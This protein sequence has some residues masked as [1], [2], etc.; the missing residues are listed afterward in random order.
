[1]SL[2]KLLPYKVLIP[3][4]VLVG[5]APFV[6]RPHLIEKLEMLFEGSLKQPI[7]IFDLFWHSWPIVLLVVKVLTDRTRQS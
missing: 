1:M 5:L 2:G 4:A 6:P 3:M 7:D